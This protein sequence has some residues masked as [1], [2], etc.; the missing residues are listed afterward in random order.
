MTT[1]NQAVRFHQYGGKEAV[2]VEDVT[3][4]E[5]QGQLV[6]VR[7]I[8]AGV[9]PVDKKV[10]SGML[11]AVFPLQFPVTSGSEISGVITSVSDDVTAFKSGD[12]VMG[13]TGNQGGFAHY[14]SIDA[15]QLVKIPDGLSD[16][17]ASALPVSGLTAWQAL[18]EQGQ[19]REG[20]R[21]LIHGAAGGVGSLAVQL[22]H[23]AGAKVFATASPKNHDYLRRLGAD[24]VIDYHQPSA[25]ADVREI[26]LLLD[27]AGAGYENL[28][29]TLKPAARVVSAVRPDIAA[30]VTSQTPPV[31]LQMHGD[32]ALLSELA[33]QVAHG[34]L[35]LRLGPVYPF[36][37]A[38][39]AIEQQS[40]GQTGR[41]TLAV[42]G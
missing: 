8:S 32:N 30:L 36:A 11:S 18:F 22:A 41:A 9:N 19:L 13:L 16:A 7:V 24:E 29:Q 40:A 5:A 34:T 6:V 38:A 14:I 25:F 26:D 33:Q 37:E 42:A 2:K 1:T 4:P 12:R 20:Q 3:L 21:V 10:R 35:H 31:F 17:V 15:S 28:G 27:F 23:R 39:E